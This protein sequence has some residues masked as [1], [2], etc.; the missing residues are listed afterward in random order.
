ML[1]NNAHGFR[2]KNCQS[3]YN[4]DWKQLSNSSRSYF[5]FLLLFSYFY[6]HRDAIKRKT[7]KCSALFFG[8]WCHNF[9]LWATYVE[10][11]KISSP[12]LWPLSFNTFHLLY[13][14]FTTLW[15]IFSV[16]QMNSHLTWQILDSSRKNQ[17]NKTCT[18][19]HILTKQGTT[20]FSEN[21]CCISNIIF[22]RLH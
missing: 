7:T 20:A 16:N 19:D 3:L 17:F 6:T 1:K 10:V 21:V 4:F 9:L 13:V 2:P 15:T 18:S 8:T 14:P 11:L 22:H 12:P 5:W